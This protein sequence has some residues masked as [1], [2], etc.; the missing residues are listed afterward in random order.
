M[1]RPGPPPDGTGGPHLFVDDLAAPGL[2][3]DDAHHLVRV[4]R[5][6]PGDRVTVGDGRG[7]WCPAVLGGDGGIETVGEVVTVAPP[8]PP[9]TIGLTPVKG[10]RPEWAVQKLTEIG[11]DGVVLLITDRSVVRW[12][13]DRAVAHVRRLRRVAREAAMQSRRVRLPRVEGPRAVTDV[14]GEGVAVADPGATAAPSLSAPT[15]L[16]GP[17]GGWS[18]DE[19]ARAVTRVALA[20][21]VLRSETAAVAAAVM[22]IGLREGRLSRHAE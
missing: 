7:R 13:G 21:T 15:V 19:R 3:D 16:V 12:D 11:V 9:V 20:D 8:R 10:D 5:R 18:E 1:S 2:A 4:L 22:L 17:E 14:L 6:R